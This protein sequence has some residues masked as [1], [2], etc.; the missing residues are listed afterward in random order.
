MK[1]YLLICDSFYDA[2]S[3]SDCVLSDGGTTDDLCIVKHVE[4]KP[5]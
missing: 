3:I 2:V 4:H 5:S 1:I